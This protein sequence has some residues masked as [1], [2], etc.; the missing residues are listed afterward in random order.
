MPFG[1]LDSYLAGTILVL[2]LENFLLVSVLILVLVFENFLFLA[3]ASAQLFHSL[4]FLNFL[5][6]V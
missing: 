5:E 6:N 2:V 1:S 3:R 4:S